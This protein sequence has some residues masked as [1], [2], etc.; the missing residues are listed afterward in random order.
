MNSQTISVSIAAPAA[1]VYEFAANPANL[2]AWVP[3]FCHSVEFI[4]GVWLV[5]SPAGAVVFAFVERN[6]FGVLDHTVTLPSGVKLTNPMRVIPNGDGSEV[7]F[8]LFQHEGMSEQ[9]FREDA[10]LVRSDLLAL[11]RIIESCAR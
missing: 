10:A 2:P 4:N 11:R 6:D 5:Q 7:L 9:Q 1:R 3:S 8:T